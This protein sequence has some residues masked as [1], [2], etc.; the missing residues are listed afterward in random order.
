MAGT[1]R[2]LKR[3]VR[4]IGEELHA[5]KEIARYTSWPKALNT[6][7]AK[8]DIQMMNRNGFQ[9]P[10]TV[11][12][13]LLAKHET[14]LDYF[15]ARFGDYYRAYDFGAA[16]AHV[17]DNP[18]PG[19]IWLCWWQGLDQA[20]ELVKRCVESIRR[21]AG[22]HEVVVITD[23]NMSDY[24]EIPECILEKRKTGVITRTN[25]SDLL[26]LSLLANYGGLWLDST[27]LCTA[28]LDEI[29]FSEPLFSI[30]R[31]DYLH[32]SIAGGY[33]AGYSLAC[34]DDLR[35]MFAAIRDF[36]LE[37]W[38]NTDFLVDY[39]MVDYMIV[40]AQ[41]H[42]MEIASAFSSIKPN[43]PLCD[44]LFTMLGQ[45]FFKDGWHEL[46]RDTSLFK[47]S[48]K[49]DFPVESNG[50]PTYYGKLISGGFS[51]VN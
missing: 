38:R 1:G 42:N 33:F 48:W 4:R 29:V 20:P 31:P 46:T 18:F 27:F 13:R 14:L 11:K 6:F 45:P 12:N 36:F 10:P 22:N 24:V 50:T 47:L 23:E 8:A 34:N 19:R 2:G 5:T 40:L 51:E 44:D 43:N 39:L 25:L 28:S 32:C 30:K 16:K 17:G 21:N 41:R 9:E 26:R 3:T 35:W 37:Y 7:R 49:F 15:E